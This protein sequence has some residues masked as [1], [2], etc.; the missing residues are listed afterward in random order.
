MSRY[1]I[2]KS[3]DKKILKAVKEKTLQRNKNKDNNIFLIRNVASKKTI[4]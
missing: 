4:H 1:M 3:S 2:I